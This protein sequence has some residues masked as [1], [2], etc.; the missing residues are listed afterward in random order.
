MGINTA[1]R[2]VLKE[3]KGEF[4]T[5]AL[6]AISESYMVFWLCGEWGKGSWVG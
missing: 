1:H 4:H 3:A 2:T 5:F 6:A